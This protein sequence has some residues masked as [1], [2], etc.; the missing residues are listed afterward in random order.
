MPSDYSGT[1]KAQTL[2]LPGIRRRSFLAKA[3]EQYAGA[4]D[5]LTSYLADR[6]IAL[7]T[8]RKWKLGC[9]AEPLAG[10]EEY[11]GRLSIP[12]LTPAG[13][14]SLKFRCVA[15]SD[16]RAA[17]CVKYLGEPGEP[18]RLFGVWNFRHDVPTLGL[19]EGELDALVATSAGLRSVGVPGASKWRPYWS[20]L[21]EGYDEVLLLRDGDAAGRK[22]AENIAARLVNCRVVKMPEGHDVSSFVAEHGRKALMERIMA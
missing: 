21:F 3:T 1:P 11:Q 18:D 12:Y 14:V 8:A 22:M 5:Q 13:P 7:E 15:H 16:C 17:G 6:G 20:Y 2:S 10:H 9:V 4:V 19:C